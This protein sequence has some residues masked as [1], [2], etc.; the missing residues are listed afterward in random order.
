[1]TPRWQSRDKPGG[2]GNIGEVRM[3]KGVADLYIKRSKF[4]VRMGNKAKGLF[5]GH[6]SHERTNL[7]GTAAGHHEGREGQLQNR[8]HP[9]L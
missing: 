5:K 3:S 6:K 8:E 9:P 4:E 7:G 1:M 2:L